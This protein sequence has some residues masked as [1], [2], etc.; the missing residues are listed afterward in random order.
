MAAVTTNG[1]PYYNIAGSLRQ[2]MYNITGS[3]GQTLDVGLTSVLKVNTDAPAVIT[4]Y[5]VTAATPTTG[6]SR[7]TFTGGPF[8]AVNVEVLGN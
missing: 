3:T 6:M 2:Q 4:A 8:T 5:T 7:I 1:R